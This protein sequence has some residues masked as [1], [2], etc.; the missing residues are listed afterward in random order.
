MFV[1]SKGTQ[2]MVGED[3]GFGVIWEWQS[4]GQQGQW[5]RAPANIG[6][7]GDGVNRDG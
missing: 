5:V 6:P 1:V 3:G 4:P 7:E 2:D